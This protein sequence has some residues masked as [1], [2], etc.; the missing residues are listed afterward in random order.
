M[1]SKTLLSWY[2]SHKRELP[3]RDV[4]NPYYV[5]VS[6]I[7]LQQTQVQTVIPYFNRFIEKLPD[8]YALARVS[9]D[10]LFLLWEGLGYYNRAR[11]L[12]EAAKV[13][14]DNHEG[15]IPN[16]YEALIKLKGI[17]P[18]TAGA[19]LSMAFNKK[20]IAPDGNVYRILSRYFGIHED[21]RL[22][23]TKNKLHALNE[24]LLIEPYNDFTQS[25]MD[26]GSLVCKKVPL[27]LSCPLKDGCYAY[28][29]NLVDQLPNLH[30]LKPKQEITYYTFVLKDAHGNFI[31]SKTTKNLLK[32]LYT[33]PQIESESLTYALEQL[34]EQGIHLFQEVGKKYYTHTFSHLRWHMHVIYG[35]AE[36]VGDYIKTKDLSQFPM[37]TA[38]KKIAYKRYLDSGK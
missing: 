1:F 35:Y 22:T 8:V 33:Y 3:W 34:E 5:W 14:V 4:K 13:I 19:I 20:A 30:P 18:Y 21:I 10:A 7:M 11:Y 27:C 28:N 15:I 26:F 12:K 25:F 38:H 31:L 24:S 9:D 6:E 2:Q 29:H 36:V 37:P 32:G 16:T 23:K 17:G